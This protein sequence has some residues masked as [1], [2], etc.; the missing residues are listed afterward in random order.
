M[1]IVPDYAKKGI[2]HDDDDIDDVPTPSWKMPSIFLFREFL[3]FGSRSDLQRQYLVNRCEY[4][5]RLSMLY[6]PEEDLN[7]KTNLQDRRS[8]A[9]VTG[10]LGHLALKRP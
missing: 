4:R 7:K 6:M 2:F 1:K 8:K 5:N 9:K 10:L 3:E